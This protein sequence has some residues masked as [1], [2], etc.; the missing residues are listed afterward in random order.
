MSERS[1]AKWILTLGVMTALGLSSVG[2]DTHIET[3]TEEAAAEAETPYDTYGELYRAGDYRLARPGGRPVSNFYNRH[4]FSSVDQRCFS[5]AVSLE[6]SVAHPAFPAS[7]MYFYEQIR[8]RPTL[9]G[10]RYAHRFSWEITS[11]PFELMGIVTTADGAG[12]GRARAWLTLNYRDGIYRFVTDVT[13]RDGL[14]EISSSGGGV[15]QMAFEDFFFGLADHHYSYVDLSGL[16]GA[17]AAGVAAT[18]DIN[19]LLSNR[20]PNV[21]M[22]FIDWT[23]ISDSDGETETYIELSREEPMAL[24]YHGVEFSGTRVTEIRILCDAVIRRIQSQW[25]R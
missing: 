15:S 2:A 16:A 3:E 18:Q 20:P 10:G 22:G 14:Y 9:S 24:S 1:I 4:G 21:F 19:A 12:V 8:I 25:P 13:P 7:R 6:L 5:G 17:G 23:E 11:D